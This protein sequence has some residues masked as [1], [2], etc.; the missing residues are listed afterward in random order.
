MATEGTTKGIMDT[1][2]VDGHKHTYT[3]G[4]IFTSMVDGH[5][6]GIPGDARRGMETDAA[7]GHTHVLK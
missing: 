2:V 3:P 6:H 4:L 7:N 5:V 1:T